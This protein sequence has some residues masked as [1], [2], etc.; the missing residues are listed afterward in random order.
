MS[1]F[2]F[3]CARLSSV[4]RPIAAGIA[5]S[6]PFAGLPAQRC[7]PV[8]VHGLLGQAIEPSPVHR[9]SG[10]VG[11]SGCL[12]KRKRDEKSP[13]R[14]KPGWHALRYPEGRGSRGPDQSHALRGTSGRATQASSPRRSS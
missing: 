12:G 1:A 8:L 2:P 4:S 3:L 11:N 14:T 13:G 9:P 10:F 6:A 5:P 7:R